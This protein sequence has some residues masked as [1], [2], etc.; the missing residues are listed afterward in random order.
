MDEI[1][2][3][4]KDGQKK[5]RVLAYVFRIVDICVYVCGFSFIELAIENRGISHERVRLPEREA[6]KHL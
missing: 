4:I 5:Y 2:A 6:S 1:H 3:S